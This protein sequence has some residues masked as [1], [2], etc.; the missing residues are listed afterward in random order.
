MRKLT[1]LVVLCVLAACAVMAAEGTAKSTGPGVA[2]PE[3]QEEI[4]FPVEPDEFPMRKP[5]R[6]EIRKHWF[7][8]QELT[9]KLSDKLRTLPSPDEALKQEILAFDSDFEANFSGATKAP[10]KENLNYLV[11]LVKTCQDSQQPSLKQWSGSIKSTVQEYRRWARTISSSTAVY[12]GLEAES[13]SDEMI[14]SWLRYCHLFAYEPDTL[15][16]LFTREYKR[17]LIFNPLDENPPAKDIF[18]ELFNFFKM[19]YHI[20]LKYT[21]DDYDAFSAAREAYGAEIQSEGDD[22]RFMKQD[23]GITP[24]AVVITWK[25]EKGAWRLHSFKQVPQE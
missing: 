10:T 2:A 21:K 8:W 1:A 25:L 23:D 14:A 22:T 5:A 20:G 3:A 13:P 18:D 9:D 6:E 11:R 16:P 17:R 7:R 12:T 15:A 4:T 19:Y 24:W